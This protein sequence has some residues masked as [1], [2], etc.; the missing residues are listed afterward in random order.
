MNLNSSRDDYK[1]LQIVD[2]RA[3]LGQKVNLIGV[4]V[5]TGLPKKSRGTGN[6][7]F[8]NTFFLTFYATSPL[9]LPVLYS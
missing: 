6:F 8:S 9:F 2:A 4:V 3:A 5:E 1:F 7:F